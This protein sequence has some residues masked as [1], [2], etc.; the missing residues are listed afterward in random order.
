MGVVLKLLSRPER[1]WAY[2]EDLLRKRLTHE[3]EPIKMQNYVI[4]RMKKV[5]FDNCIITGTA[6]IELP[7]S[8]SPGQ[9]RFISTSLNKVFELHGKKLR[10]FRDRF[11]LDRFYLEVENYRLKHPKPR[12]VGV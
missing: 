2:I 12:I 5:F 3:A 1:D 7:R 8:L 11:F 4:G 6:S 10:F 9:I